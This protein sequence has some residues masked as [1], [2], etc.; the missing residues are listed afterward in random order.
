MRYGARPWSDWR[1]LAALPPEPRKK[2][3]DTLE[4]RRGMAKPLARCSVRRASEVSAMLR[5]F[6]GSDSRLGRRAR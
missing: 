6:L 5:K 1:G 3:D 4:A 2:F